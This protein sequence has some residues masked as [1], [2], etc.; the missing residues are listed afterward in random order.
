M[1]NMVTKQLISPESVVVIGGSEDTTKPGGSALK[2]LINN[3]FAG[4]LYVVNPKAENVQGQQTFKSVEDLPQVDCA[5]MA[6]PAAMCVPAVKELCANKG[7]KAVIIFS[8]GF[9][10]DG[11]EGAA[12]EKEIVATVN[13]YG[14]SLIGPNCIGVI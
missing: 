1:N 11:P 6:I 12:L 7:C 14:A 3:N 10:E 2:N 8:A 5:I 9:G 4:K 13:Q